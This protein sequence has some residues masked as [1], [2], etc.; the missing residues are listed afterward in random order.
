MPQWRLWDSLSGVIGAIEWSL[1]PSLLLFRQV[2]STQWIVEIWSPARAIGL[3]SL[4]F[5]SVW[6]ISKLVGKE[7]KSFAP[8]TSFLP[9][10]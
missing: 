3:E 9:R 6:P 8:A 5:W 10:R 4:D 2:G 7:S 1:T